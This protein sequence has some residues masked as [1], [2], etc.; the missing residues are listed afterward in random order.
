MA[1]L[2][3]IRRRLRS[4]KNSQQITKAMKMISAA[5][6]RRAQDRA[7]A[8]RP[9]A[10]VLREVMA[11]VSCR[12]DRARHPLLAEREEKRVAD[13]RGR[14]RPRSCGRV[15]HQRQPGGASSCSPGNRGSP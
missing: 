11:S 6:L 7:I 3:D 8:A 9:Y 13:R 5:R 14:R 10:R 1:S 2:I 4:I 12:V 15:Q